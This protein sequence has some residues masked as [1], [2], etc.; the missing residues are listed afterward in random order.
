MKFKLQSLHEVLAQS[1]QRYLE[2]SI[3]FQYNKYLR[4]NLS[5]PYK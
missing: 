4:V 3:P 2:Q 1:S 5:V